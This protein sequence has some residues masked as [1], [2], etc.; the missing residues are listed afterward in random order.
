VDSHC[1]G[2]TL[3]DYLRGTDLSHIPDDL[4]AMYDTPDTMSSASAANP[5]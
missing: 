4:V 1:T 2:T 5:H 3:R